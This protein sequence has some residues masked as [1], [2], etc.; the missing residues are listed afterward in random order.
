MKTDIHPTNYQPVVFEDLNDGTQIL[1]KSTATSNETI[2]WS[3]G[4][5]YPLIKIHISSSSHPFYTGLE[6]LVDVEG[7][8]DRFK[9]RQEA[10][11]AKRDALAA[12]ALKANKRATSNDEKVKI[13][14]GRS[15]QPANKKPTA[16]AA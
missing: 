10:A 7:R 3:D 6:K 4:N 14:G 15:S 2:V 13:G 9:A 12:K 8:V 5:T 1:V 11:Q 16:K